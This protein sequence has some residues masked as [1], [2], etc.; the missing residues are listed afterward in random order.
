[1][2]ASLAFSPL[3]QQIKRLLVDALDAGEWRPGMVIP[4][5]AELA[6]RFGVSQGTVRKAIDELAADKILVR[7]QGKGTFVNTH[8]DSLE[9]F[10]FLRLVPMDGGEKNARSVP[11]ECWQAKAGSETARM[12]EL[13]AGAPLIVVRR[14]LQFNER[15]VVGD[16]I[17][18]PEETF[19]GLGMDMLKAHE[20]SLYSLFE[21][22]FGVHMTRAQERVRAVLAD[23]ESAALLGVAEGSPL[24][25]VDRVSYTYG[26]RPMEWRRGLYATT[27]CCYLNELN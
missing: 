6:T 24:L 8:S 15:N 9:P 5:E 23:R 20:G 11:L 1:M 10:R 25:S 4:S 19:R 2:A 13:A 12:L 17:Y 18:L 14:V 22:K 26:D 7:R 21:S 3:Y 27:D 16:E